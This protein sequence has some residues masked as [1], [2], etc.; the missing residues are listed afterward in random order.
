MNVAR[1]LLEQYDPKIQS[2]G[3]AARN[4]VI[5]AFPGAAESV[6][7]KARMLAYS[8][9]PGYKGMVATLIFSKG[10][11][12]IGIPFGATLPDPARL[13]AGEGKVHRHIA[14]KDPAELKAAAVKALLKNSLQAW[15]ARSSG[16]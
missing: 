4:A 12:K 2:L 13:L 1:R 3:M 8:Y 10:G 14:L 16:S 15:K 9:G 11:V 5:T 6:D 7:E